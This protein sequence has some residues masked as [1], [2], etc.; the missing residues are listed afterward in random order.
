MVCNGTHLVPA[1]VPNKHDERT[2]VLFDI[3]VDEDWDAGVELLAHGG[4]C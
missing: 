3:V 4:G 2:V 1:L